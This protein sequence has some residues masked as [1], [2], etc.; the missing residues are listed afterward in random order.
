MPVDATR[1]RRPVRLRR[2]LP[3][4]APGPGRPPHWRLPYQG[5]NSAGI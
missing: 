2:W 1:R 3:H 4:P 5:G